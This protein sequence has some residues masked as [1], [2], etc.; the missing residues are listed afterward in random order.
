MCIDLNVF[1]IHQCEVPMK[2][3]ACKNDIVP[4]WNDCISAKSVT[5]LHRDLLRF[6]E[7][8]ANCH[9]SAPNCFIAPNLL[10]NIQLSTCSNHVFLEFCIHEQCNECNRY[11]TSG[12]HISPFISHYTFSNL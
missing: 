6:S 7:V 3:S 11:I 12:S 4:S 5:L 9:S 1:E 10:A 8:V 2:V